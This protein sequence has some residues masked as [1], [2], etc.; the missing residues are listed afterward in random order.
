MRILIAVLFLLPLTL[1][2]HSWLKVRIATSEYAP[3]SSV[4]MEHNGMINH[5]ITDAFM[6][7][8]VEV[9]YVSLPWEAALQASIAGQYDAVSFG[10]FVRSREAEFWH[11]DPITSENLVFYSNK[12]SGPGE[13]AS[14]N[15]VDNFKMIITRSYLY[16][17]E[18]AA[19]ID[20]NTQIATG[21]SD[22][23]SLEKLIAG[24]AQMFPIDELT[25]WYILQRDFDEDDR[26]K[27][28]VIAPIISTV[29][30]HLLIPRNSREGALLRELFNK[31]LNAL[32]LEG[33]LSRYERLLKKGYYQDP[34]KKVD[35][36]RR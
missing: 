11:S 18:L 13:W 27:V 33:K 25:G 22:Y 35:F 9:E 19:Y 32:K 17:D 20:K 26:D 1:N 24:E 3:Y 21:E 31:G 6:Q 36:D 8:G 34:K 30:T 15:D 7:V 29:T 12:Q 10:N 28:Q 23:D 4:T 5:I 14:L 2:A 16:N